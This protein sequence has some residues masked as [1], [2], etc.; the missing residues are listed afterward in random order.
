MRQFLTGV[1]IILTSFS[2]VVLVLLSWILF[3]GLTGKDFPLL[4]SIVNEKY[5]E[6][7]KQSEKKRLEEIDKKLEKQ[8]GG[9]KD[10]KS[11]K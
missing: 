4:P 6:E 8:W 7:Y 5:D 1:K 11:T 9:N 3:N 2:I 10:S